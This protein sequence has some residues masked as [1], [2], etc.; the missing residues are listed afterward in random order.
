MSDLDKQKYMSFHEKRIN[1]TLSKEHKN[2]FKS[3]M[4]SMTFLKADF[5]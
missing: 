3:L 5:K 2:N 1:I 4:K